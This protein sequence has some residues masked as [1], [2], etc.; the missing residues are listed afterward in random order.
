RFTHAGVFLYSTEPLTPAAK[1]PETVT[2]SEKQRR[3]EALMLAQLEVSRERLKKR[4]AKE[5]SVIVDGVPV[6]EKDTPRGVQAVGRSQLEAPEV[7][8]VVYLKNGQ[9]KEFAT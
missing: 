1:M 4:V 5:L 9:S 7:D 2:F 6:E 8:G 3:R